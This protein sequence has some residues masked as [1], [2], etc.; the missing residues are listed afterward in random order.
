MKSRNWEFNLA[1]ID[2]SYPAPNSIEFDPAYMQQ[3][4][5]YGYQRGRSGV[6]WQPTPAELEPVG[7][8]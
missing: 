7:R 6:L 1:S 5:D 3:L 4:F 8:G 2:P